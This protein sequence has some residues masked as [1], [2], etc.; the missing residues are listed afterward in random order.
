MLSLSYF[1]FLVFIALNTLRNYL[2]QLLLFNF[3]IF[4]FKVGSM[5]NVGLELA[6]L[7]SSVTCH[8][9]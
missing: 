5:P 1:Q 3:F 7:R 4:F 2:V 9:D 6:T 8:T